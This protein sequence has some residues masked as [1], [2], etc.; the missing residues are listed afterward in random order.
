MK[1][2]VIDQDV[3]VQNFFKTLEKKMNFE[4]VGV[5]KVAKAIFNLKSSKDITLVIIGKTEDNIMQ[6]I[7]A[8][9]F[10]NP[11]IPIFLLTNNPQDPEL[12]K[13]F[14]YGIRGTLSKPLNQDEI[15]EVLQEIQVI[16]HFKSDLQ[17]ILDKVPKSGGEKELDEKGKVIMEILKEAYE[18]EQERKIKK[19]GL[20]S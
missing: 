4:V 9:Q 14:Y 8:C 7:E 16:E 3:S 10:V 5:D 2:F 15:T 18:L 20:S 1:I 17:T 19:G 6:T 13:A 12:K 11:N